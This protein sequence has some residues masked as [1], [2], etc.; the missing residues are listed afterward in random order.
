MSG[1]P[2]IFVIKALG[3]KMLEKWKASVL[4]N[5]PDN[6]QGDLERDDKGIFTLND[7]FAFAGG[8]LGGTETLPFAR[9]SQEL[10]SS[11]V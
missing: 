9:V 5:W 6:I 10:F 7:S 3:W 8:L 4:S 1:H 11:G 2:L